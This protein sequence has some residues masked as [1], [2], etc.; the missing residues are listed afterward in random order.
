MGFVNHCATTGTPS[1]PLNECFPALSLR[2]SKRL[3]ICYKECYSHVASEQPRGQRDYKHTY[4]WRE[5]RHQKLC[6]L[7]PSMVLFLLHPYVCIVVIFNITGLEFKL[8]LCLCGQYSCFTLGNVVHNTR[9]FNDDIK[10][11]SGDLEEVFTCAQFWWIKMGTAFKECQTKHLKI[12]ITEGAREVI[13]GKSLKCKWDT[14]KR[15]LFLTSE[16]DSEVSMATAKMLSINYVIKVIKDSFLSVQ[17]ISNQITSLVPFLKALLTAEGSSHCGSVVV[18]QTS[19]HEMQ[20]PS[21]APHS[22]LRIWCCCELWCRSQ[23]GLRPRMAA[24]GV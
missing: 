17:A 18:S 24:A 21:L 15:T 4:V 6:H 8:N 14:S 9:F 11:P 10:I 1:F 20:V 16:T 19:V 23:M 12:T 3:W 7:S 2:C 22:G 13:D 5:E